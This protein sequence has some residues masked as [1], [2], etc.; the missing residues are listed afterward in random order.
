M[1][2]TVFLDI[3][4]TLLDFNENARLAAMAAFSDAGLSFDDAIF[5]TFLE[6]NDLLWRQI[7]TGEL[8]R[9]KLHEIRWS[10]ILEKWH[11]DYD[12]K[13]LE[14]L[15]LNHITDTAIPMEGAMD[16]L[17]YL[18]PKYTVCL[19]SNASFKPQMGR[20]AH[21][22]IPDFVHHI[23]L[24][25]TLG[26]AKPDPGFFDACL[27]KLPGAAAET[28]LF[29][30]DSLSADIAGAAAFGMKTCWFNP[31]KEPAPKGLAIDFQVERLADIKNIV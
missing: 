12:G 10:M 2:Q 27:K 16:L 9:K 26:F 21:T 28:S 13:V 14:Q 23:F 7:E 30:G 20:L 18:Y 1:I 11:I 4:N 17:S 31:K 3:D 19:A 6:V 29:I 8:T 15:F 25:E 5:P 22:E 24:S